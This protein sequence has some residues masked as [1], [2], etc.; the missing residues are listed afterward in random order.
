MAKISDSKPEHTG[1]TPVGYAFLFS[2]FYV[3]YLFVKN[4]VNIIKEEIENFDKIF[5]H[6]TPDTYIPNIRTK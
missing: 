4:I 1:S 2:S 3:K 6:V 5:Y